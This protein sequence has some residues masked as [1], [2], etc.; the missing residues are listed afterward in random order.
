METEGVGQQL[1]RDAR[2]RRTRGRTQRHP[3]LCLGCW[4]WSW[5][6]HGAKKMDSTSVVSTRPNLVV[7]VSP[8]SSRDGPFGSC[9]FSRPYCTGVPN[10]RAWDAV[11]LAV[12]SALAVTDGDQTRASQE[13][14]AANGY[15]LYTVEHSEHCTCPTFAVQVLPVQDK[16]S[17]RSLLP[18][19]EG[20]D[21]SPSEAPQDPAEWATKRLPP[22]PRGS[23]WIK[24][25]LRST[26]TQKHRNR[27]TGATPR[28]VSIYLHQDSESLMESQPPD[29]YDI[30]ANMYWTGLLA[31]GCP[32]CQKMSSL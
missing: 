21:R 32:G 2:D 30:A 8:S 12:V 26:E 20:V 18:V 17:T 31:P 25:H 14:L 13:T 28:A 6:G 5:T 1:G 19:P 7:E 27:E 16:P 29:P 10:V 15:L 24:Q 3:F 11:P 4:S 23:T 22:S 9:I